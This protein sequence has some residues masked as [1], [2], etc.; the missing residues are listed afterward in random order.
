MSDPMTNREIEDV[1]SSIRRLVSED[2]RPLNRPDPAIRPESVAATPV[3]LQPVGRLV[4]T[5]AFRVGDAPRS[6]VPPA[7][8]PVLPSAALAVSD[9]YAGDAAAGLPFPPQASRPAAA[10]PLDVAQVWAADAQ[11]A[12]LV[13][14]PASPDIVRFAAPRPENRLPPDHQPAPPL[15]VPPGSAP[16]ASAQAAPAATGV[17]QAATPAMPGDLSAD[18]GAD[19]ADIPADLQTADLPDDVAEGAAALLASPERVAETGAVP[20]PVDDE[21]DAWGV[22]E[23]PAMRR[24]FW[25]APVEDMA[26]LEETIAELEA[27]VAA[28]GEEFEP[29]GSEPAATF[30][31]PSIAA[32]R[33]RPSVPLAEPSGPRRLHLGAAAD[34]DLPDAVI[35]DNAASDIPAQDSADA[36]GMFGSD[37]RTFPDAATLD[38]AT[39]DEAALRELVIEIIRQELQGA[40]GE[41]ITRNVRKLVRAE[42]HRAMAGREFD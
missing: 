42:I 34:S 4:L 39:F 10:Q 38:A 25:A 27:A 29:D 24:A 21:D 28:S 9:L 5:P 13:D 17:A 11:E 33:A 3:G 31:M 26:R 16:A 1:L 32:G 22:T 12:A 40:L 7:A 15:A 41:R 6:V 36:P 2:V 14:P 19:L 18:L 35:P 37:D 8:R 30:M 23:T 20:A